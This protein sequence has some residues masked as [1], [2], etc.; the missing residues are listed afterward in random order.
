M[1]FNEW[2]PFLCTNMCLDEC[3]PHHLVEFCL[4]S[5]RS[6]FLALSLIAWKSTHV[7]AD[8]HRVEMAAAACEC[9]GIQHPPTIIANVPLGMRA[10]AVTSTFPWSPLPG[11][12][13]C[14]GCYQLF[15]CHSCLSL[16]LLEADFVGIWFLMVRHWNCLLAVLQWTGSV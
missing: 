16:Y 10:A 7:F 15:L 4:S 2:F 14:R 8:I 1:I 9:A 13:V 5:L 3:S 6:A 12:Q 11:L